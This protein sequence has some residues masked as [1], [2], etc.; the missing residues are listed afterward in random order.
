MHY[1]ETDERPIYGKATPQD[2]AALSD[3][4]IG[5]APIPDILTPKPKDELN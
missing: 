4:G 5:V 1:G 3:E 2:A